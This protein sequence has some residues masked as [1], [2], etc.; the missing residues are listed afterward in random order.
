MNCPGQK[1][2]KNV[3]NLMDCVKPREKKDAEIA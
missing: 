1:L 3:L 2:A